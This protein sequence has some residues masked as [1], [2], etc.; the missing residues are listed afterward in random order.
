MSLD[1][2]TNQPERFNNSNV[3]SP[4]DPAQRAAAAWDRRIG[5]VVVQNH[6]WRKIA[7]GLLFSNILLAGGLTYQSMKSQVIPYVVTVDKTTGVVEKAGALITND[8]IPKEA[9]IKYFLANFIQNAR[10]IQL[11][12]VQ[13]QKSQDKA[14][15]FLTKTAA[16][17]FVSMQRAEKFQ[18]KYAYMTIQ[19]KIKS[20]QKIPETDSYHASW[21]E[22]EFTVHD[23]KMNVNNYEG[24]FTI[25]TLPVKDDNTLLINP[26][27]IYISDLNFSQDNRIQK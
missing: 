4:A 27:G 26:L 15:S 14:Y 16:Q 1:N 11:D 21:S 2:L 22:E 24:V 7:L 12:P 6:N 5:D 9:E 19:A 17:K 23:G 18:Q 3:D 10:N 25:I 20:I 8:Y 13:Q